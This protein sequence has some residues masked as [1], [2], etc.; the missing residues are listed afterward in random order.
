M[1]EY[2]V[3]LSLSIGESITL[4]V[5]GEDV[6]SVL[7]S[8]KKEEWHTHEDNGNYISVKVS[9]VVKITVTPMKD[10]ETEEVSVR[11]VKIGNRW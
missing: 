8:I 9:D 10:S 4:S 11:T 7:E 5:S 1:N 6:D 3:V 2:L